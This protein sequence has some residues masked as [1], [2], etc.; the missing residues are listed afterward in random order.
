MKFPSL[1]VDAN[2]FRELVFETFP[3]LRDGGGYQFCRCKPISRE[4]N[5]LSK[6]VLLSPWLLKEQ[7]GQGRTYVVPPQSD[8]DLSHSLTNLNEVVKFTTWL[9]YAL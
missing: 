8:I 2:E 4:L 5:P 1:D 3:T 6:H 9:C 7:V